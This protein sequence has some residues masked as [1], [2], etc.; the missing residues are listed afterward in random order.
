[1]NE[2][3][4]IVTQLAEGSIRV[5]GP[6]FEKVQQQLAQQICEQKEPPAQTMSG[7]GGESL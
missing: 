2:W 5:A 1:L 4:I 7:R 3:Q 6:L